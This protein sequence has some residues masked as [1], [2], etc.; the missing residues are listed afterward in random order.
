MNP[1]A[2][3]RTAL[4]R[5]VTRHDES[6]FK[7]SPQRW[8]PAALSLYLEAVDWAMADMERGADPARAVAAAFNDRL[9]E[10]LLKACGFDPAT[11]P[12]RETMLYTPEV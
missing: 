6:T 7:R 1:L 10:K 8:H 4:V 2:D 5:A 11:L 3:I 12:T 9:R